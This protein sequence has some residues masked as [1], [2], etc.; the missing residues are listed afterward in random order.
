MQSASSSFVDFP[1]ACVIMMSV[2]CVVE[3]VC[4]ASVVCRRYFMCTRVSLSY[5]Q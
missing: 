3:M 5:I 4:A 2:C 1:F